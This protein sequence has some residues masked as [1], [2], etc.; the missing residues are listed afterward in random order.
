MTFLPLAF[1]AP[2]TSAAYGR[3]LASQFDMPLSALEERDF[4]DG[5][6]KARPLGP[7]EGHD[8]YLI[9]ALHGEP[10]QSVNDKLMRA[11]L[12]VDTLRS[13]GAARVTAVIPY[14]CY[15]R[16][17][18][19]T[20]PWDP[21]GSRV[22]AT[23][24]EAA[25]IDRMI[26]IEVHN[27]AAFDNAFR[28]PVRHIETASLFA[29]HFKPL[30]R[31]APIVA[32]SPDAGG[33]KRVE[34]FRQLLEEATG[35]AVGNAFVEKYRSGGLVSGGGL[36][37]SVR[38]KIAVILDDLI[39]SGGTLLRAAD[40]C[41]K[42]GAK[43]VFAAATHGLFNSE[44]LAALADSGLDGLVVADTVPAPATLSSALGSRLTILDSTPLVATAIG[45]ARMRD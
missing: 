36:I 10:G 39:S 38:G 20:K 19:R 40:A 22:V 35:H 43:L 8:A 34:Q 32:V 6:H 2:S 31:H 44:A 9:H 27:Q 13:H 30:S 29:E 5:E 45:L 26:A 25:G 41:R 7:V 14:L 42:G 23:L 21:V 28:R 3:R 1:F 24:F 37:G 11:L 15:A 33:A 16:K 12:L 17:D 18:R 4:E